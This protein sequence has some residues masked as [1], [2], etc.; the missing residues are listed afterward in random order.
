MWTA[1]ATAAKQLLTPDTPRKLAATSL[2]SSSPLARSSAAALASLLVASEA[3]G[4]SVTVDDGA[5]EAW[6]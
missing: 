4:V 3:C 5:Q 1:D 2:A 6:C